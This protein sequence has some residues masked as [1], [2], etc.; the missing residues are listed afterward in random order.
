VAVFDTLIAIAVGG[1]ILFSAYQVLARSVRDLMDAALPEA[2]Q[3]EIARIIRHHA[4]VVSS[5]DLRTRR[6][7][8][9]RQ[10][11]FSVVLCRH[12]PLG[13]AHDLVDHVEKEIERAIGHADVVAHAESCPP[14]CRRTDR[15]VLWASD[16]DL[17]AHEPRHGASG[18]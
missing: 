5:H 16:E 14:D 4:F 7:G 6:A 15:C 18:V 10:I 3:R 1:L 12:L 8:S 13:E 9:Q 2:E 17:L 11:D